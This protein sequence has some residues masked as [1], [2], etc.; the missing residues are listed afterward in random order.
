Q[1]KAES[2]KLKTEIISAFGFLISLKSE[3]PR[4]LRGHPFTE[5]EW[6][7]EAGA[8]RPRGLAAWREMP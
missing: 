5:G 4:P 7:Q 3:L 6:A 8:V 1:A 2:R